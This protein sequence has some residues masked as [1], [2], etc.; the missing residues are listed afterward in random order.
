M[1]SATADE[2]SYRCTREETEGKGGHRLHFK[3][4]TGDERAETKLFRG[5][6]GVIRS[7]NEG[8]EGGRERAVIQMKSK[9]KKM[10]N[11]EKEL[12]CLRVPGWA[13]VRAGVNKPTA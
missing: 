13:W 12:Q 5:K 6:G 10:P 8:G 3:A 9:E 1:R 4:E 11:V 2:G 7:R